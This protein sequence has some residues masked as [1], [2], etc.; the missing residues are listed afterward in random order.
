MEYPRENN[1]D[2]SQVTD[3]LYH[4]MFHRVHLRAGFDL[5][6]LVVIGIYCIS[7]SKST[8][9]DHDHNDTFKQ[10]NIVSCFR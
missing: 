6:V 3:K 8:A 4:V 7:S 5:T 10:N 1:T 2:L 9:Y